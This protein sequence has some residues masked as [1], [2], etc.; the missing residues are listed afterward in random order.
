[1]QA[2]QAKQVA[3]EKALAEGRARA[4][5]HR[6]NRDIFMEEISK[7]ASEWGKQYMVLLQEMFKGF[8]TGAKVLLTTD[9][10]PKALYG[11]SAL[12]ASYYGIRGGFGLAYRYVRLPGCQAACRRHCAADSGLRY[13]A[14][15]RLS[16]P[17]D[18]LLLLPA[19]SLSQVVNSWAM[20]PLICWGLMRL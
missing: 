7:S 4:Q 5:E 1:V 6:E 12:F 19:A 17:G 2:E 3:I 15:L 9:Y 18:S 13:P 20:K 11:A 10:G 14:T 16:L 8:G